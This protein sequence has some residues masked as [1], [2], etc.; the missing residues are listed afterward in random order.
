MAVALWDDL[1]QGVKVLGRSFENYAGPEARNNFRRQGFFSLPQKMAVKNLPGGQKSR[2]PSIAQRG[3]GFGC[4]L[5]EQ[6][7]KVIRAIIS[8]DVESIRKSTSL[9]CIVPMVCL[10]MASCCN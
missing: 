2:L 4:Q 10:P 1:P 5:L 6:R 3:G 8:K 7:P 9:I